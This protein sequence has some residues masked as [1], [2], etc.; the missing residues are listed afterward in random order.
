MIELNFSKKGSHSG[1]KKKILAHFDSCWQLWQTT[2]N[3]LIG[4]TIFFGIC[5]SCC[6]IIS[7]TP[8][9]LLKTKTFEKKSNLS[10]ENSNYAI[11]LSV[12]RVWWT[13][14]NNL[15][16]ST[17]YFDNYDASY[18]IVSSDLTGRSNNSSKTGYFSCKKPI[19]TLF[20]MLQSYADLREQSILVHQEVQRLMC[21]L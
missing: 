9:R 11:F 20:L 6:K 3:N 1:E 17:K 19:R 13:S 12:H 4:C 21:L 15:L 16:N 10:S 14:E 8:K 2:S 7:L 18:K 5:G